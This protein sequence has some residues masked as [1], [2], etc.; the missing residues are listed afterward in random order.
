MNI[1]FHT[2][3]LQDFKS[4][5][6]EHKFQ[7]D[8]K[9]GLYYIG[10]LNK[11][12]PELGANGAG[13]TS[14][15]DALIWCLYGKTGKDKRPGAA[16]NSW[17]ASGSQVIVSFTKQDKKYTIRRSRN[18]N[19]LRLKKDGVWSDIEQLDISN[20]VMSEEAFRQGVLRSQFGTLFMDFTPEQQSRMFNE[21]LN[22][23]VWLE[24]SSKASEKKREYERLVSEKELKL[25]G[26]SGKLGEIIDSM[27]EVKKASEIFDAKK[28]EKLKDV[29]A[30]IAANNKAVNAKVG[31]ENRTRAS[32]DE[33]LRRLQEAEKDIAV[34]SYDLKQYEQDIKWFT[35]SLE[36]PD[37]VTCP[38]CKQGVS[39]IHSS[40]VKKIVL[41]T[42]QGVKANLVRK[43]K[44]AITWTE[45]VAFHKREL[46]F[47]I[48][49]KLLVEK[50]KEKQRALQ[51]EKEVIERET[52]VQA[53]IY[54]SLKRRK[55]DVLNTQEILKNKIENYNR[56]AKMYEFWATAFK[57]IRLNLIDQVLEEL[58]I[59][60]TKHAEGLGLNG[61]QIQ[62]K[63]ERESKSGNV[64]MLFQVLLYPPGQE[65][66]VKWD[67]YS[68]G[69]NQRWQLAV[70]FALSEI[71]M[72][73]AG[74]STNIEVLDEPTKGLS[75]VGIQNLLEHL[76][77]RAEE[78]NTAIYVIEQHSL[79]RGM[80]TDWFLV[81]KNEQGS[82]VL[83]V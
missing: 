53:E 36:C 6:G 22:L 14:L 60:T 61:W 71:V 51:Y 41:A 52:N 19:K 72:A 63:T 3:T 76:K 40:S 82:R 28:Q 34:L 55:K 83:R 62:F 65:K 59:A 26:L 78:N 48:R 37:D 18:P 49:D 38:T 24:S 56:K 79:E 69:E 46:D 10:G 1:V 81:Q 42:M 13:K 68:G 54:V 73:R 12:E 47:I 74:V 16:I 57:E 2:V 30:R 4:F 75:E 50:A 70:S 8:R 31:D 77:L 20:L 43:K 32:Y 33:N 66:P 15:F 80:F 67:S 25:S 58:S 27:K 44:S 39:T 5:Q 7:L 9:P 21:A 29:D 64:S 45:H 35:D 11:L 17:E 23:G